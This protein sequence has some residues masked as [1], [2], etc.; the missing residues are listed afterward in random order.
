[1]G[2][3]LLRITDQDNQFKV[4]WTVIDGNVLMPPAYMVDAGMLQQ[5]AR[6]V[7]G[8]LQVIADA[9]QPFTRPEFAILLKRL[10]RLGRT[11][12]KQLIGPP[13]DQSDVLQ[14]LSAQGSSQSRTDLNI[15]LET[16]KLFVPWGFVFS[17]D[18][19]AV[20]A[21]DKLTMSLADMKG[22]WVSQFNIS[23]THGGTASLPRQRKTSVRKLFALHEG[24]W[25]AAVKL[26]E[27]EDKDCL[28][29]LERL[30]D[31]NMAPV[32]DWESFI[33]TWDEVGSNHDSVLYV[34]GHS[35]GQRIELRERK[36]GEGVDPKFEISATD[37][38]QF[39]KD[40]PGNS[41]AIFLFNGCRTAAPGSGSTDE[42]PITANFLKPSRERGYFGFIGTETEVTNLFACRYGTEFLWRLHEEGKTVG[43][44]F[45]EL[46]QSGKLFPQNLLYSCYAD[47]QFCFAAT[48]ASGKPS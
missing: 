28:E 43:A 8:Q 36:K 20:P 15:I 37:F 5:A 2:S 25:P 6:N 17:G 45:D 24:M 33:D 19:A 39:K 16:E 13:A 38:I 40:Q 48:P 23:V 42:V 9:T 46:L 29:K 32:F 47:R 26:L 44:A 12:F 11:L 18:L 30:L 14:Y 3:L 34:F 27:K 41:V 10:A 21:E 31:G 35:D 7:R 4:T 1:M 22:F